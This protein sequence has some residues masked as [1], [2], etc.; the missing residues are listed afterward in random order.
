MLATLRRPILAWAANWSTPIINELSSTIFAVT[1]DFQFAATQDLALSQV[2][3]M[4]LK[5]INKVALIYWAGFIQ[6]SVVLARMIP[7]IFDWIF[8]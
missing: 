6:I 3:L 8:F 5:I 7:W 4:G 2:K 1:A